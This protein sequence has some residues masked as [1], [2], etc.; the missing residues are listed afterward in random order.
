[1]FYSPKFFPALSL[2]VCGVFSSP[3]PWF[4]TTLVDLVVAILPRPEKKGFEFVD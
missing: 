2:E 1:M 4:S 3:P